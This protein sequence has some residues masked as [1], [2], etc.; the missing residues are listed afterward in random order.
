MTE[1]Q[2]KKSTLTASMEEPAVPHVLL[3]QDPLY[4]ACPEALQRLVDTPGQTF[5]CPK[6]QI[7]MVRDPKYTFQQVHQLREERQETRSI[8][9]NRSI[10][11]AAKPRNLGADRSITDRNAALSKVRPMPK[12][13]AI[14]AHKEMT[15][16]GEALE[17]VN[18]NVAWADTE[19]GHKYVPKPVIESVRASVSKFIE[20]TDGVKALLEKNDSREK[21]ALSQALKNAETSYGAL[22]TESTRLD[23]HQRGS[24]RSRKCFRDNVF[25]EFDLARTYDVLQL[26]FGYV[27]S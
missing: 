22:C 13:L 8:T 9:A 6:R 18:R 12:G 26:L 27:V 21:D 1:S 24:T 14:K 19:E 4:V 11:A 5:M 7:L 3:K 2:T 20:A 16:S 15:D 10:K 23:G 17:E 25:L